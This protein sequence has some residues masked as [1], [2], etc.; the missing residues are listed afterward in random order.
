[1]SSYT[2]QRCILK[3]FRYNKPADS[4]TFHVLCF[5]VLSAVYT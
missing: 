1:M 4:K 3:E 2:I 5:L